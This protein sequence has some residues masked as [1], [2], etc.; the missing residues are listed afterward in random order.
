MKKKRKH[1]KWK[2]EY[3]YRAIVKI[4]EKEFAKYGSLFPIRNLKKFADFLDKK[5]D[6]W[7]WF[8]VYDYNTKLQI[9]NFTN[10]N[11]PTKA[12]I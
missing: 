5:F 11:K 7:R 9:G 1:K 3:R 8:N 6:N 12:S 10:R 2:K 4:G